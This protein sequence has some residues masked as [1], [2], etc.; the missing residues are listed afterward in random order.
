MDRTIGFVQ[1]D[2]AYPPVHRDVFPTE[3]AVGAV[4][5]PGKDAR[6]HGYEIFLGFEVVRSGRTTVPSV[7]ITYRDGARTLVKR[8]TSTLALCAPKPQPDCEPEYGDAE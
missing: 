6:K 2:Y 7:K 3:E 8:L 4:L 1:L 5:R